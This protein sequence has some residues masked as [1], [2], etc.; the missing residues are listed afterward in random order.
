VGTAAAGVPMKTIRIE[1]QKAIADYA[2][3]TDDLLEVP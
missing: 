1:S 3:Y 2:D